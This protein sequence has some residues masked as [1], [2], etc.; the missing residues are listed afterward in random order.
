[1]TEAA[2]L[3]IGAGTVWR[4]E[5]KP[6]DGRN[7]TR[8]ALAALIGTML[9]NYDF[10]VYGTASALVFSKVF[11]PSISPQAGMIASFGAYAIGFLA[12]PLGGLF[13]SHYGETLGRK[14]VLVSTLLLMGG[15]TF[16]IGCL[17]TYAT[18][19]IW[20]PILLVACRFLQGFGAGAEQSGGATLLTETAPPGKRGRLASLVMVGA[21]LG[22]VAG[23]LAW[24]AVQQLPDAAL[25]AWGWRAI[26]WSSVIVTIAAFVIRRKLA[27]SPVFIELKKQADVEHRAPLREVARHGSKKVLK[28]ILM[29]WGVSTQSYTYQVFMISYLIGVVGFSPRAIPPL[30]LAASICAAIAAL[31]AGYLSDRVGRR[32][33]T[34]FITGLLVVTPFLVFPGLNTGSP[35]LIAGLLIFGYMFAAQ[36]VTGVHMSFFP[37]MFGSRYRYAGVTL[38]REFSSIIGGGIAPLVCAALLA[39]SGNSWIPVA[40]YMSLTMLVSFMTTWTVPETLDRDLN[41][42]DDAV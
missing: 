42:P 13:F 27:E 9:E 28:V 22:T 18:L 16:A 30:Q 17:P 4:N 15:S 41:S 2:N 21:A 6:G 1:M 36:G 37:E 20:A 40:L 3:T 38:G 39:W 7:V 8:A 23:A 25:M 33:M 12:R 35:L 34:L 26:F 14:W 31:A 19:G 32:P 29:N 24:T 5:A 10:V 11:F